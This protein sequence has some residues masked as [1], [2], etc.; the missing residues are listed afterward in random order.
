MTEKVEVAFLLDPD[1]AQHEISVAS[2]MGGVVQLTGQVDSQ[3][4][5]SKA[6]KVAS[7]VSGVRQVLDDIRVGGPWKEKSDSEILQG[8]RREFW[9]SPYVSNDR[10]WVAVNQGVVTLAGVVDSFEAR[11]AATINA[12][13]GGAKRVHNYLKVTK[14]PDY[15]RPVFSEGLRGEG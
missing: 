7:K 9:W 10:V 12:F 1:V 5:K 11:R 15:Y 6:I 4:E 2:Y 13:E 3:E 14:G 8:V